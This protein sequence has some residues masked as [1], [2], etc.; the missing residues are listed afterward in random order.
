MA[1]GIYSANLRKCAVEGV[2]SRPSVSSG[3]AFRG[4]DWRFERDPLPNDT[5]TRRALGGSAAHSQF[6][7][8]LP[9][10]GYRFIAS[11]PMM[12]A[13]VINHKLRGRMWSVRGYHARSSW[14]AVEAAR[15]VSF[16][17]PSG[18]CQRRVFIG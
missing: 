1:G 4:N 3:Q 2:D 9:R 17:V 18:G 13:R 5:T 12:M 11:L 6:I 15:Q 14:R 8:T 10:R 16:Q 7:K